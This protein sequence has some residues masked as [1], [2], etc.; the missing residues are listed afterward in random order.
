MRTQAEIES[1]VATLEAHNTVI[2]KELDT[3]KT[4]VERFDELAGMFNGNRQLLCA[5]KWVLGEDTIQVT[6]KSASPRWRP[7]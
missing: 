7:A 4:D 6:A 1:L 3:L 5:L 2:V